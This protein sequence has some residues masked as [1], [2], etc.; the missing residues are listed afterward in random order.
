MGV[1]VPEDTV[2]DQSCQSI[3]SPGCL[4]TVS[5]SLERGMAIDFRENP[6]CQ[7]DFQNVVPVSIE[8]SLREMTNYP[9]ELVT[10]EPENFDAYNAS[11]MKVAVVMI[12]FSEREP[13]MGQNLQT[14]GQKLPGV[15]ACLRIVNVHE[16]KSLQCSSFPNEHGINTICE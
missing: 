14:F 15:L 2:N 12:A 10:H 6:A 13:T 11:I 3:L 8:D 5:E 1:D 7:A 9:L 16:G 4:D